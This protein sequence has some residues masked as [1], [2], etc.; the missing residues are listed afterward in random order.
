MNEKDTERFVGH[1]REFLED[2][3]IYEDRLE[4]APESEYKNAIAEWLGAMIKVSREHME[5]AL[6]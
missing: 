1:L 4:E 6:K 5:K 2:M 3:E